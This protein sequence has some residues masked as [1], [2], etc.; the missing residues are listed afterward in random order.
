MMFQAAMFHVSHP[1][2]TLTRGIVSRESFA[3][4]EL[5]EDDVEEI[6]DIDCADD[7]AELIRGKPQAPRREVHAA[8]GWRQPFE[9][10]ASFR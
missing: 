3:D 10:D 6:L 2:R 4:A 5:R 7:P 8:H 9:G 1:H